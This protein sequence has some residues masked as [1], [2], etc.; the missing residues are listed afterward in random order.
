MD[1]KLSWRVF[2][3]TNK[4]PT[5]ER[6]TKKI[7]GT[8]GE[9]SCVLRKCI[10]YW[11]NSSWHELSF[12]QLIQADN[13]DKIIVQ[14]LNKLSLLS[15]HWN[16]ELST[17]FSENDLEDLAGDTNTGINIVGVVFMSFLIESNEEVE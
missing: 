3:N 8:L 4:K 9:G 2:L 13:F 10:L 1:L 7:F 14:I 17:D 16:L 15:Y 5:A 12:N 6:I 11:K